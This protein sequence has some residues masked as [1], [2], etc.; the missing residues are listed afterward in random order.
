MITDACDIGGGPNDIDTVTA[1]FDGNTDEVVVEMVLCADGDDK[2]SYRVYFD[3]Q[4]GID[5][6]PDTLEPNPDCMST[7]DDRMTHKGRKDHGLGT[8]ELVGNTLTFWVGADELDPFLVSG[9]IV[10]VW[11]DTKLKKVTDKTPNTEP[12]DGC[13]RPEVAS[14]VLSVI[15]H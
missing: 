10:L 2:T 6:G 13:A 8:I 5:D 4:G 14:E 15:V 11:T 3:H 12:G 7:W 9:D 1:F